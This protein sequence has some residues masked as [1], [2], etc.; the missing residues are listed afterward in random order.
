[1]KKGNIMKWI[2]KE[3]DALEAGDVIAEVETDKATVGFEVQDPGFLA[4]ILVP[5]GSI[6]IAFI[7]SL[8]ALR[9]YHLVLSLQS[10]SPRKQML[11][12]SQTSSNLLKHP[13]PPASRLR[14]HRP[15][16]HHHHRQLLLAK[17][18]RLKIRKQY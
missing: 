11:Q 1:M 14:L 10:L 6:V 17:Q 9:T 16:H 2:K 3:G 18:V 8:K 13:K 5:E 12:P 7:F 15:H 4:K